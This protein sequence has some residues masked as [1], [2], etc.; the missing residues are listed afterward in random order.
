MLK[1]EWTE[2]AIEDLQRLDRPV[3][4]RILS[5]ISWFSHHFNSITPEPL[6]GDLA[7]TFKLRIG[8]WRVIYTIES[9]KIVIQAIDHRREVYK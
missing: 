4:K 8:D 2:D 1:I 6:S 9:D 3:A 5:K 7:G